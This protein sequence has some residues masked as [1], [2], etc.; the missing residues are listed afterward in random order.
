[1]KIRISA[2]VAVLASVAAAALLIPPADAPAPS[3][4]PGVVAPIETVTVAGGR[5][6][7]RVPGEFL[8]NGRVIKGPTVEKQIRRP[9]EVMKY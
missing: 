5:F 9:V 7:Y 2:A 1:M 3:G 8:R 6:Q 4:R